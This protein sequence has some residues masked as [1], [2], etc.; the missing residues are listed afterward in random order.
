MPAITWAAIL[1]AEKNDKALY[2]I[3]FSACPTSPSPLFV[4][5]KV[6][7]RVIAFRVMQKITNYIFCNAVHIGSTA[8]RR[9]FFDSAVQLG[10][11][12]V[13]SYWVAC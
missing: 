9:L 12:G 10:S 1:P 13:Q 5:D 3:A 2:F 6:W 4:Y 7:C 11:S 8:I